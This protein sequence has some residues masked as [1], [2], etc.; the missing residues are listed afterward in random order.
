LTPQERWEYKLQWLKQPCRIDAPSDLKYDC[1]D[2]CRTHLDQ[3]QYEYKPFTGPYYDSWLFEKI[4]DAMA[5][6]SFIGD[7]QTELKRKCLY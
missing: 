2:W 4:T 1:M 7:V 3:H 5:F 6:S